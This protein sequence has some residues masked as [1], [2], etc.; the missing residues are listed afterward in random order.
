MATTED[1]VGKVMGDTVG[2]TNTVLAWI[3]DELGL[4]KELGAG[5]PRT[6]ADIA[7][8]LGLAERPVREWLHAMTAAGYLTHA[9]ETKSFALPAEHAP[10][11]AQESGPVFFSGVHQEILGLIR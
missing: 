10:V 2:L 4:W 6:S 11:L 8:K 3:G 5:G 7:A 9:S 1:F